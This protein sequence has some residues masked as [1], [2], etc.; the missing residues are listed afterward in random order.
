MRPQTRV[1]VQVSGLAALGLALVCG[2]AASKHMISSSDERQI[3]AIEHSDDSRGV[4]FSADGRANRIFVV[5]LPDDAKCSEAFSAIETGSLVEEL[6]SR[7]FT[8][9]SCVADDSAGTL[10]VEDRPIPPAL[11]ENNPDLEFAVTR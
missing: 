4:S 1:A 5:D 11:V 8:T 3:F 7:G 9:I 6:R 2:N 10:S